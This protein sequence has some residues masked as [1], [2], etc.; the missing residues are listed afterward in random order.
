MYFHAFVCLGTIHST[1][2]DSF[3]SSSVRYGLCRRTIPWSII[4]ARSFTR[5]NRRT[6][7]K[8]QPREA[9]GWQVWLRDWGTRRIFFCF[10]ENSFV[11]VLI[12]CER[13][14]WRR[15]SYKKMKRCNNWHSRWRQSRSWSTTRHEKWRTQKVKLKIL[16]STF[17]TSSHF[18]NSPSNAF[19]SFRLKEQLIKSVY[20][21]TKDVKDTSEQYEQHIK[22]LENVR[23]SDETSSSIDSAEFCF[24]KSIKPSMNIRIYRRPCSRS[25]Q[26]QRVNDPS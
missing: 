19:V 23:R 20:A 8:K 12:V 17:S 16:V 9:H 1:A 15:V 18:L 13:I 25:P 7:S 4:G 24:R 11:V 2:N 5:G 26:R 21:S 3:E 14:E 22:M 6:G 10:L